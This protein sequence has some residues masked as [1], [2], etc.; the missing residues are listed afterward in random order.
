MCKIIQL[1]VESLV[2]CDKLRD[3]DNLSIIVEDLKQ[4]I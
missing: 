3:D 2:H 1:V 4:H